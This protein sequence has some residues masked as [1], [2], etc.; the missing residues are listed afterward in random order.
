VGNGGLNLLFFFPGLMIGFWFIDRETQTAGVECPQVL[1]FG[2]V[3]KTR[4][5]FDTLCEAF[6]FQY[7]S[8]S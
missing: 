2:P 1:T 5:C 7:D 4:R 8:R 6:P 3:V